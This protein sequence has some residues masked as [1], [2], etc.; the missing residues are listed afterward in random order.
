MSNAYRFDP[1]DNLIHKIYK[2]LSNSD[3]SE[4]KNMIYRT[5]KNNELLESNM[6]KI[7]NVILKYVKQLKLK[8]DENRQDFIV[9]KI[10]SFI[11]SMQ[12]NI[13]NNTLTVADIGGGNGNVLSGINDILKGDKTQFICVETKDWIEHYKY[14]NPNITYAFW[15]NNTIDI[16]DESCDVVFCM[17]SLHHMSDETIAHSLNE[18]R[19]ILKK[20]GL[21]LMKEHDCNSAKTNEMIL[22][23]HHLYHLLDCAYD[24]RPFDYD[25][26]YNNSIYNFKSKRGWRVLLEEGQF[27]YKCSKNRFLDGDY[28]DNDKKNASNLYWDVYEK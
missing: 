18:I 20:G 8:R 21:L 22:W 28:V 14:D 9:S 5:I 15:N 19:R 10:M 24:N 17:V 13:L 16:A 26:Y 4:L 25:N 11:Q 23:E 3:K 7:Y 12:P 6:N 1:L 27:Q 2:F